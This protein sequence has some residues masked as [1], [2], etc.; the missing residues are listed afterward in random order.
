MGLSKYKRFFRSSLK[1][2][3]VVIMAIISILPFAIIYS[4]VFFSL[5]KDIAREYVDG[6]RENISRFSELINRKLLEYVQ[7]SSYISTDRIIIEGITR[8][9]GDNIEQKAAFYVS[10]SQLLED[11]GIN[12][13]GDQSKYNIYFSNKSLFGYKYFKDIADIGNSDFIRNTVLKASTADVLWSPDIL[14]GSMGEKYFSLYRKIPTSASN[15]CILEIQIPFSII[16]LYLKSMDIPKGSLVIYKDSIDTRVS[17]INVE[18]V[19]EPDEINFNSNDYILLE[20]TLI[21]SHK[22]I[23]ALIR[24][25]INRK[26]INTFFIMSGVFLL[27]IFSIS[28]VAVLVTNSI[29][30]ELKGFISEIKREDNTLLNNGLVEIVGD[31][32][33]SLIKRKFSDLLKKINTLHKENLET[34]KN[35]K[36]LEVEL[37]QSKLNPHMLYNSL[38]VIK[39]GAIS[40]KDDNTIELVD[41]MTKYYRSVLNKGNN[42]IKIKEEINLVKEYVRINEIAHAAVYNLIVNIDENIMECYIFKLLLQ[43][44]VE[45]AISHGLNGK[46]G[47]KTITITGYGSGNDIILTIED[48]GYGIKQET[49]ERVLNLCFMKAIGGYGIKNIINMIRIYFGEDYGLNIESEMGIYTRITV[50]IPAYVSSDAIRELDL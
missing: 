21:N 3:I 10:A 25:D 46:D 32:E 27:M 2:R 45:N 16:E 5:K 43:P 19:K 30:R 9:F 37:L 4:Y 24:S 33:V 36:I 48:N 6:T 1:N 8:D 34:F 17:V 22:L 47:E 7:K 12:V 38:S 13:S 49:I 35:K 14:T 41:C 18:G 23:V 29:T 42:V 28:L 31:D 26:Y 44:I 20:N 40:N 50:K 11:I 15:S 39:W